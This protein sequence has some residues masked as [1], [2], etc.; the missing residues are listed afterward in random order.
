MQT[1]NHTFSVNEYLNEMHIERVE[2]KDAARAEEYARIDALYEEMYGADW[3]FVPD[4]YDKWSDYDG[5]AITASGQEA[6][7]SI[8]RM[9]A[10]QDA[11][12]EAK[13]HS[14]MTL[15]EL[16]FPQIN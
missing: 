8:T 13:P 11:L 10:E 16:L 12:T 1:C 5:V 3:R 6:L 14:R 7:E 4:D 15:S 2:D 9:I